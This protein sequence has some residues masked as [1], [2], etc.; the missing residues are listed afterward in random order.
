M[1]NR[2][3]SYLDDTEHTRLLTPTDKKKILAIADQYHAQGARLLAVSRRTIETKSHYTADD[4]KNLELI[5]FIVASDAP[6]TSAKTAIQ[7]MKQLGVRLVVLTGDNEQVTRFVAQKIGLEIRQIVN[8][9]EL[10]KL[11][12]EALARLVMQANVFTRI[13]PEHKLRIIQALKKNALTVGFMGDG[14]NDAP[15]LRS[16]D[17]GISFQ[18][19]TDVAREAADIILLRRGLDVVGEGITEGR[20]TFARIMTYLHATISSNFGNMLTV[21][22]AAILLPFIPLLPSQILLLNFVS[23]AP[24]LT[25]PS[26]HVDEQELRRPQHWNISIIS[27][28]M[29]IFG[30]ISS[31]ADYATFG[32]LLLI[33]QTNI[34]L[35]RTGWFF[36][37]LLT[38]IVIIFLLRSTKPLWKAHRPSNALIL[39]SVI[40]LVVSVCIMQSSWGHIFGFTPLSWQL[41]G[42]IL[43]IIIG[44][45]ALTETGKMLLQKWHDRHT[46][47]NRHV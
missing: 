18:E 33:T 46:V 26:D 5:G 44:Y 32:L 45:S 4:E 1:I 9:D 20:K 31:L 29:Y 8:G 13:T 35:F 12:E 21:A 30:A 47:A 37:S 14:I 27:H 16:A 25:L 43:A 22:S 42:I 23:D 41:I 40:A 17:V 39:S 3:T 6:K 11:D 36:E 7:R 28:V 10:E 38:E 15:A 34:D 24:M 19:A 2:C